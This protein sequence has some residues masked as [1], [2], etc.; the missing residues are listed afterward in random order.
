RRLGQVFSGLWRGVQRRRRG[1]TRRGQARVRAL[2]RTAREQ[3][4]E[5]DDQPTHERDRITR[6][7][8]QRRGSG[9]PGNHAAIATPLVRLSVAWRTLSSRWR[10][11]GLR[12]R[13]LSS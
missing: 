10:A 4:R 2:G 1:R 5:E 7:V 8:Y 9:G 6:G 13:S 11:R 12:G 3:E